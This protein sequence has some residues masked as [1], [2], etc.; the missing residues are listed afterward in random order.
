MRKQRSQ[1]K[2]ESEQRQQNMYEGASTYERY[3]QYCFGFYTGSS[4]Y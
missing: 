1:A 4:R 2:E 3:R